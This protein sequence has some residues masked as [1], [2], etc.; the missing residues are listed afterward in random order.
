MTPLGTV[1]TRAPRLL[2]GARVRASGDSAK[3]SAPFAAFGGHIALGLAMRRRTGWGGC[4]LHARSRRHRST[5]S[6]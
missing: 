5:K 6:P 2:E 4:H 1:T 3:K